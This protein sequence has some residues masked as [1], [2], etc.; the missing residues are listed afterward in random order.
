MDGHL[1]RLRLRERSGHDKPLPPV[2]AKPRT[3]EGGWRKSSGFGF[4]FLFFTAAISA[5]R[6]SQVPGKTV[7]TVPSLGATTA[8]AAA[9]V[10]TI[11]VAVPG[12]S[13]GATTSSEAATTGGGKGKHPMPKDFGTSSASAPEVPA[14]GAETPQ[15]FEKRVGHSKEL[16]RQ[17]D[18]LKQEVQAMRE[19]KVS[20]E[21]LLN[22]LNIYCATHHDATFAPNHAMALVD[23]LVS[24]ARREGHE[25]A[26]EIEAFAEELVTEKSKPFFGPLVR[27]LF[28]SSVKAQAASKVSAFIKSWKAVK[29][30]GS[31]RAS[32]SV[33]TRYLGPS[34]D[35]SVKGHWGKLGKNQCAKCLAQGHW[36]RD[37]PDNTDTSEV[38]TEPYHQVLHQ[39]PGMGEA[40][41]LQPAK[42]LEERV[43]AVRWVDWSGAGPAPYGPLPAVQEL[44][45]DT[46]RATTQQLQFRDPKTFRAEFISRTLEDRIRT[47]ALEVLGRVGEVDPPYLTVMPLYIVVEPTKP[48]LCHDERFLNLWTRHIPFKLDKLSDVMRYVYPGAYQV[49]CDDKSGGE[50]HNSAGYRRCLGRRDKAPGVPGHNGP[51]LLDSRRFPSTNSR[52]RSKGDRP[53]PNSSIIENARVMLETDNQAVE[54]AWEGEGGKDLVLVRI[55]TG[56]FETARQQNYKI[57]MTYVPPKDNCADSPSRR[58]SPL[59]ATLSTTSWATVERAFGPHTIDW[60]AV[61]SNA[62]TARFISPTPSPSA[63]GV[64]FFNQKPEERDNGYIFPPFATIGAVLPHLGNRKAP[65]TLIVPELHPK[66]YWWAVVNAKA[67]NKVQLGEKGDS[68]IILVPSKQGYVPKDLQ[69]DLWA[70]V[71]SQLPERSG[72]TSQGGMLVDIE[73]IDRE[74]QKV[75]QQLTSLERQKMATWREF[76]SFLSTLPS[77]ISPTLANPNDVRR[78]LKN[79]PQGR[80]PK[81]WKDQIQSDTGLTLR[82]AEIIALDRAGWKNR[83]EGNKGPVPGLCPK[84]GRQVIFSELKYS[85]W[86][87]FPGKNIAA[88]QRDRSTKPGSQ[89]KTV[90]KEFENLVSA[91]ESTVVRDFA[92]EV[93]VGGEKYD[94]PYFRAP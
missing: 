79:R 78:E 68:G 55:L 23:N 49:V 46:V 69:W 72:S 64:D 27:R 37:C 5:S 14:Q 81:R 50:T 47:G 32:A 86:R 34:K 7:P 44:A 9:T 56:I 24:V 3:R 67:S 25:R 76:E 63:E 70:K 15:D 1:A 8:A 88:L 62:K 82:E 29:D 93:D 6:M 53:H 42:A 13:K 77:Q 90:K 40:G 80:P 66:P 65:Y 31:K 41:A 83:A 2:F 10:T 45:T 73:E 74:I 60:M 91:A 30:I 89:S 52:E 39:H 92:N 20:T 33:K 38:R 35:R 12:G 75:L 51:R 18:E 21:C 84:A 57:L 87:Y 11:Q 26:E 17:L 22:E 71:V 61:R 28:G 48:R 36:A 94:A 85:E 19:K 16:K 43:S 58:L 4:S 59:D 54:K